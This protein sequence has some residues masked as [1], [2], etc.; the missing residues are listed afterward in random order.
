MKR[1]G[2]IFEFRFARL[3]TAVAFVHFTAGCLQAIDYED[4]KDRIPFRD[5]GADGADA[6][7]ERE[8]LFPGDTP[9]EDMRDARE[10][11]IS[12]LDI[13]EGEDFRDIHGDQDAGDPVDDDEAS[14]YANGTDCTSGSQCCST[15]C[16]DDVCCNTAC[17]GST[18]QRCDS[19]SNAGAGTCGYVG[20]AEDPDNEC[21][22]HV[23]T[24]YIYGWSGT[25][26]VKYSEATAS[27]GNCSGTGYTCSGIGASC[28]GAGETSASCDSEG[29]KKACIANAPAAGYD[30]VDEVCYISGQHGCDACRYCN[31]RGYCTAAPDCNNCY[32]C[33][34]TC[35]WC[36]DGTCYT[37]YW[38]LHGTGGAHVPSGSDTPTCSPGTYDTTGHAD[39]SSSSF[40]CTQTLSSSYTSGTPTYTFKSFK[41]RRY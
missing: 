31:S 29:C 33:T 35:N 17:T 6:D 23:C 38:A 34:G 39:T 20:T 5:A 10:E 1:T 41:C 9:R 19:Y 30:A 8:D 15:H 2:V 26:C 37:Y 18:C 25:D 16:V 24:D 32:G 21:S 40:G 14:C 22:T 36:T 12:L 28:T 13:P 4:R 3:C 27:N 7:V 11:D